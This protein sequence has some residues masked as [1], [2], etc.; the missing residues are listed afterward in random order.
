M[1]LSGPLAYLPGRDY[2]RQTS[3]MP[4]RFSCFTL[5]VL[6]ESVFAVVVGLDPTRGGFSAVTAIAGFVVAA[7]LWSVYFSR[8][9]SDA[10]TRALEQKGWANIKT[11][12]YGYG[13]LVLYAGVLATGIAIALAI[14]GGDGI[15]LLGFA[16]AG[17]IAGFL[18]IWAPFKR[19]RPIALLAGMLLLA[20]GAVIVSLDWSTVPA[21][22]A[23]SLGWSGLAFLAVSTDDEATAQ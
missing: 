17:V 2:P 20:T 23:I 19:G 22:I 15:P 14:E 4:E 16:T 1:I 7:A 5:I 8:Y 21:M 10:I 3:H 12:V 13:H 9:D 6:G 18:I 11:F